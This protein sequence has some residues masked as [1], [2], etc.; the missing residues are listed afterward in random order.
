MK[1]RLVLWIVLVTGVSACLAWSAYL[2]Y[3]GK[4]NRQWTILFRS[5][6]VIVFPAT[7][8]LGERELGELA[9]ASF[10]ITNIGGGELLIDD[11]H[12]NCACTGLEKETE[13]RYTR[14]DSIRL[15]PNETAD[16]RVR[17]S[18]QGAIGTLSRNTVR[19]RTNDAMYPEA[20]IEVIT[21][22]IVGGISCFP[23]GAIFGSVL[24]GESSKQLLEIRDGAIHPRTIVHAESANHEQV[25]IRLLPAIN[26]ERNA[27]S[28]S[29][30]LLVGY[31]EVTLNALSPGPVNTTIVFYLSDDPERKRSSIPVIGHVVDMVEVSP[32][33]L[34]L[35]RMSSEGKVYYG[36]CLFRCTQGK[37]L[38]LEIDS[39][40][41]GL[42]AKIDSDGERAE[43]ATVR[44]EWSPDR[45]TE[46]EQEYRRIIR[47]RSIVGDKERFV[48]VPVVCRLTKE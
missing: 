15:G 12:M 2:A 21:S 5:G 42:F 13:G 37:P 38:A 39:L 3:S 7:L 34:V 44:I 14:V 9:T 36:T 30:G 33:L 4:F 1:L 8:E 31:L 20:A 28:S 45:E 46:L 26:D 43:L 16:L 11:V 18:V 48:E 25:S 27:N 47:F 24:V 32:T 19:F 40:P 22:K 35:P 10:T 29:N 23:T 17:V 6:P 41:N